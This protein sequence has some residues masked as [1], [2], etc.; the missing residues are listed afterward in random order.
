MPVVVGGH[1]G[2][3]NEL[4]FPHGFSGGDVASSSHTHESRTQIVHELHLGDQDTRGFTL[5]FAKFI[6]GDCHDSSHDHRLCR[7]LAG[8]VGA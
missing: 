1:P 5:Q 7:I 6:A 4:W 8:W 3:D 2:A